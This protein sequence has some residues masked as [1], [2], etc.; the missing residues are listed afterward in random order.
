MSCELTL[1]LSLISESDFSS[2]HPI[3]YKD[4]CVFWNSY[5]HKI[6]QTYHPLPFLEILEA[7]HQLSLVIYATYAKYELKVQ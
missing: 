4:R 6:P 2:L 7:V 3:I 5:K 1:S